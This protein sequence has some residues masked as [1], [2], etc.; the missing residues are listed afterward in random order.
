M[1]KLN[2][3]LQYK[4][5]KVIQRFLNLFN[6]DQKEAEDIFTETLKYLYLSAYTENK[7]KED[8]TLPSLGITHQMLIIDEMWHAFI[9]TTRDYQEFCDTYLDQF[10]HH[11]PAAYGRNRDA[12]NV[13]KESEDFSQTVSYIYDVLGEKTVQ[14]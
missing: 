13:E 6:V 2:E 4:N 8:A 10:V 14:I 12:S 9:L 5:N 11:P 3:I 7:R 1:L